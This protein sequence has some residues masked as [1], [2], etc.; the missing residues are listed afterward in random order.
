MPNQYDLPANKEALL[1]VLKTDN[2][3]AKRTL[4][5]DEL[6]KIIQFLT[7]QRSSMKPE[8]VKCIPLLAAKRLVDNHPNEQMRPPS[9]ILASNDLEQVLSSGL[10][11]SIYAN[12]VAKNVVAQTDVAVLAPL[13]TV[14]ALQINNCAKNER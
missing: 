13:S 8:E 3:Y 12:V 7:I 9:Q 1:K 10:A 11:Q 5:K 14:Y 2:I 4:D 6:A